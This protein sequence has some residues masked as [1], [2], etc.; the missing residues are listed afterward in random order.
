MTSNIHP[1]DIHIG[2]CTEQRRKELGLQLET[3]S[4]YSGISIADLCRIESG[5]S[6]VSATQVFNLSHALHV[7]VNFFFEKYKD[8]KIS[9]QSNHYLLY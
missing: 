3:L 8:S 2:K 4:A 5:S 9:N 7:S 1:L 6:K